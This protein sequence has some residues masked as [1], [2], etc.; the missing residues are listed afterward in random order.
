MAVSALARLSED[1]I[2][3]QAY[4]RRQDDIL[5]AAKRANDY[6]L[7][8]HIAEQEKRKRELAENALKEKDAI[9]AKLKSKLGIK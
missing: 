9:I 5:L 6:K 2:M 3:R 4:L 7:M 8:E 1:K